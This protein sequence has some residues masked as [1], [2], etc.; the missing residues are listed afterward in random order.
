MLAGALVAK[1][2]DDARDDASE[3]DE[4]VQ[5]NDYQEEWGI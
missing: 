4:N 5:T 2:R 3:R 1:H